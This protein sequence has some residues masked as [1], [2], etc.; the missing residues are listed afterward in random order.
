MDEKI[1]GKK[2][3]K[4]ILNKLK[5]NYD[6]TLKS[7]NASQ[8]Q[9]ESFATKVSH[10]DVNDCPTQPAENAKKAKVDDS[11]KIK[12]ITERDTFNKKKN[13]NCHVV[14]K[15]EMINI[16]PKDNVNIVP[17]KKTKCCL[18]RCFTFL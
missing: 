7:K 5:E 15:P 4:Q 9:M 11:N 2:G 12:L 10:H 8:V 3:I 14:I 13:E 1:R 6:R 18:F 17:K 16:K